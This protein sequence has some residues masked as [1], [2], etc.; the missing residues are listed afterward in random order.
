MADASSA[1][2]RR[3]T[4]VQTGP[5]LEICCTPLVF[6]VDISTGEIL[7]DFNLARVLSN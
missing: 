7:K 2:V 5:G 6:G 1:T 4:F 3:V